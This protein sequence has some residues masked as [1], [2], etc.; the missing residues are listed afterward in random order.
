MRRIFFIFIVF[1]ALPIAVFASQTSGTVDTTNKYAWSD[2][3]G[4]VNF[5]TANGNIS[6]TDSGI[7][8]YAWNSNY[9]WI[10]MSPTSGGVSVAASGALSGY[11]W[12]SSLGWINFSGVSINSSGKFTGQASG[13]VIG[14]LTFDCTNCNVTTDY[15]PSS[16]RATVA[17]TPSSGGGGGGGG[18]IPGLFGTTNTNPSTQPITSTGAGVSNTG[19][20]CAYTTP[21]GDITGD[22]VYDVLDFN[23]LMV[24]WGVPG[25]SSADLNRDCV[26]DILDF[27]TLMVRWT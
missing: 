5:N 24:A 20:A 21:E 2:Q 11:A 18:G 22:G 1:L 8:G 7:T 12:G 13:T 17:T 3:A 6:I 16:F 23:Q 4:W 9:G 27:N 14:T 10:N 26:V 25:T 19:G 15:R